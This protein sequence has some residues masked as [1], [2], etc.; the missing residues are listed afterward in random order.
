MSKWKFVQATHHGPDRAGPLRLIVVHTMEAPEKGATAEATA[1]YF[2]SGRV[3]ASA[4]LCVDNDSIVQCVRGAQVAYAAPGANHDGFQ[5][6]HAGY[7]RQNA[8]DWNDDYSKQMLMWSACAAAQVVKL[9]SYFGVIIPI[10]RLTPLEILDG[11]RGFCGHRDVN[12]AYHKSSHTDP[13]VD[14]PWDRYLASVNWW[15]PRI[16]EIQFV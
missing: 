12:A 9:S 4:H 1:N 15:L 7:A 13:G 10:R 2:A 11:R 3:N 5:I 8:A 16:N 6:E 14:F